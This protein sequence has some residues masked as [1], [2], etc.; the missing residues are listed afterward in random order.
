MDVANPAVVGSNALDIPSAIPRAFPMQKTL[1][2]SNI[3]IIPVKNVDEVLKIALTK[4]LTRVEWVEV[5]QITKE[6]NQKTSVG[7]N[8]N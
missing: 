4:S 6:N 8:I 3:E 5:E 1:S 2:T 7:S